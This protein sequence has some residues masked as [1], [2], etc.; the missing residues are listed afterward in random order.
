MQYCS[1]R[2]SVKKYTLFFLLFNTLLNTHNNNKR[3]KASTKLTLE[4]IK[5]NIQKTLIKNHEEID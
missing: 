1:T 4:K 2:E 5:G 3:I